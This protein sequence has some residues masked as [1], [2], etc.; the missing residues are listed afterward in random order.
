VAGQPPTRWNDR[1]EAAG[2]LIGSTGLLG[3][4][5]SKKRNEV[6]VHEGGSEAGKSR[7]AKS[8]GDLDGERKIACG[9]A[10]LVK[11]GEAS[12]IGAVTGK[13]RRWT[14]QAEIVSH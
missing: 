13:A 9:R 5:L 2:Y 4:A 11:G 14:E 10:E 7:R 8:R 12:P 1:V 3:G 6:E